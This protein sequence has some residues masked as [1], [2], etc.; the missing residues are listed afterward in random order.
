MVENTTIRVYK[1]NDK[2]M[3]RKTKQEKNYQLILIKHDL[4][5]YISVVYNILSTIT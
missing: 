2:E 3:M 5:F 4:T 1:W